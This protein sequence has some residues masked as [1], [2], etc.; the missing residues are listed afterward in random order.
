LLEQTHRPSEA[1]AVRA[2]LARV[3]VSRKPVNVA[4]GVSLSDLLAPR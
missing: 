2:K 4:Q 3:Q 1:A